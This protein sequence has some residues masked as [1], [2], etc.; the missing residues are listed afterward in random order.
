MKA[1]ISNFLS[2][3]V[4]RQPVMATADDT[5]LLYPMSDFG[6]SSKKPSR[7]PRKT[8]DTTEYAVGQELK[9]VISGIEH[10]GHFI[11][12]P[13]GESGLVFHSEVCW[14]G[15]NIVY[16]LGQKVVVTVMA[17]K[18]GRGLALS[19]REP[20]VKESFDQFVAECPVGTTVTGQVKSLMDYGV[21]ITLAPGIAGLLH[22]SAIPDI[23]RYGKDSIGEDIS[24]RVVDVDLTTRRISL[25]LA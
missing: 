11:R 10:Y 1:M 13:N 8:R 12:L 3:L 2:R 18:P 6:G 16:S 7:Q 20:R 21:F 14:P 19:L 23:H 17:F 4:G 24:V 9:G 5:N 15:E 25:E 22:V